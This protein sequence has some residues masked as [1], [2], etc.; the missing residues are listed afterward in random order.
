MLFFCI[1]LDLQLCHT[2]I[3]S[4]MIQ[5]PAIEITI[6]LIDLKYGPVTQIKPSSRFKKKHFEW[7]FSIKKY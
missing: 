4:T 1:R 2:G 6:N 7:R 3:K 5:P